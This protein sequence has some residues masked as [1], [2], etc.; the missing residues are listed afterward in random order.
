LGIGGSSTQSYLIGYSPMALKHS[1]GLGACPLVS[2]RNKAYRKE[3]MFSY[4]CGFVE[5][6]YFEVV[7]VLDGLKMTA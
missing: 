1:N 5:L 4:V 3:Q 2:F 7:V 6:A